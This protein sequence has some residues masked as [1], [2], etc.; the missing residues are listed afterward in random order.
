MTAAS[1]YEYDVFFSYKRH[2]L[3]LE[4]TRW[5]HTRLKF[6]VTHELNVPEAKIFVDEDC[7]EVGDRWPDSLRRALSLSKCMVCVWSPPYFHSNWCLS[8][9]RS[10]REREQRL[11][12]GPHGLILPMRYSDG[13]YFPEEARGVQ[14]LDVAPYASTVPAFLKSA[15]AVE[16]EDVLKPF[17]RQ[18]AESVRSAPAYE[19]DW[20]VVEVSA[21]PALK[22]ELARL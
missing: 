5:V 11:N 8:E 18:V 17:A 6:W 7:I 13:E 19:P 22:I 16:F 21:P 15:R 1:D 20:P 3:T 12:R 4:W 10:F 9:Y 2:D 14:W